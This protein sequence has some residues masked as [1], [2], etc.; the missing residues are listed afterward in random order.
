M[1]RMRG[2]GVQV[3]VQRGRRTE[4]EGEQ[5][6]AQRCKGN[7]SAAIHEADFVAGVREVQTPAS[8]SPT[9]RAFSIV[10]PTAVEESLTSFCF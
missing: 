9:S 5:E 4:D 7:G 6:Y 8:R 2:I 3:L 10:I 1:L